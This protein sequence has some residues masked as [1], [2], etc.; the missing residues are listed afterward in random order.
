MRKCEQIVLS[1]C[2]KGTYTCHVTRTEVDDSEVG[3]R[4]LREDY[5]RNYEN[6]AG[7]KGSDRVREDVLKHYTSVARTKGSCDENVF[8]ILEAVELHSRSSCHTDPA[9]RKEGNEENENM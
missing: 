9:G 2:E 1:R 4:G 3:E 7:Y 5:A 6:G 8:L